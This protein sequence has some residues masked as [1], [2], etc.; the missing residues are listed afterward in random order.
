[1]GNPVR[2]LFCGNAKFAPFQISQEPKK[3]ARRHP[4][5]ET[6]EVIAPVR[7]LEA[8]TSAKSTDCMSVLVWIISWELRRSHDLKMQETRAICQAT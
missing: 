6:K 2:K 4:M 3:Q 8:N 5:Q 1:M 7:H